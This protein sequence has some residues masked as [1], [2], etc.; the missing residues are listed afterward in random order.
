MKRKLEF[1]FFILVI[2][3][4]VGCVDECN[5]EKFYYEVKL[6]VENPC[7]SSDFVV[8]IQPVDVDSYYFVGGLGDYKVKS[9]GIMTWVS[10]CKKQIKV[11]WEDKLT[12]T[13]TLEL[14]VYEEG[15][16][17]PFYTTEVSVEGGVVCYDDVDDSDVPTKTIKIPRDGCKYKIFQEAR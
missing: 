7:V 13:V 14:K 6:E 12:Q 16:K 11:K 8:N 1:F 10:D 2:V 4:M 9:C 3:G 15:R 5:G 17:A